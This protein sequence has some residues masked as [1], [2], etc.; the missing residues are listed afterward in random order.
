MKP[1]YS[2]WAL[3]W[4][5]FFCSILGRYP[6]SD[7]FGLRLVNNG[8]KKDN[9]ATK[10]TKSVDDDDDQAFNL[11]KQAEKYLRLNEGMR[12][13]KRTDQVDFGLI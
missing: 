5:S 6:P 7:L 4:P 2:I 11:L 12:F 13:R 9:T 10:E 3:Y 1:I 8:I